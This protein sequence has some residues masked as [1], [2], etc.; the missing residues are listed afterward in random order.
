MHNTLTSVVA[1]AGF[2][3]AGAAQAEP[4]T[5][6]EEQ[7]DAVVAGDIDEPMLLTDAQMDAV[8]AAGKGSVSAYATGD[9]LVFVSGTLNIYPDKAY[10]DVSA[11]II[12]YAPSFVSLSAS[13][14][15]DP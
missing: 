1:L 10:A 13:A 12:P 2:A 15:T 7:T 4:L 8:T 5:L 11:D 6:I 9:V 14:N 3:A